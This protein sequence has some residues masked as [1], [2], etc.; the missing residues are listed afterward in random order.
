V[1]GKTGFT[2]L[3]G[4]NLAI[5]FEVGPSRPVVAVI[6]GSTQEGRFEDMRALV[7]HTREAIAE[8]SATLS[9]QQ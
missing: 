8:R 1:F 7:D 3:A 4:G 6:L 5:V 9:V 2:D